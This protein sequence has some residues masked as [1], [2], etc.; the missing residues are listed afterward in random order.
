[1]DA[2]LHATTPRRSQFCRFQRKVDTENAWQEPDDQDQPNDAEQVRDCV[3]GGDIG[4]DLVG[5]ETLGDWHLA[6]A[7]RFLCGRQGWGTRQASREQAS[8][9][10]RRKPKDL[11]QAQRQRESRAADDDGEGEVLQ[12]ILTDHTE[13]AWSSLQAHR[14]DEQDEAQGLHRWAQI[15]TE[16]TEQ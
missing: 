11:R 3:R 12:T 1:M 13:E 7:N 2:V 14:E 4:H 5:R 6:G 16:V 15:V 10:S 9:R 8:R